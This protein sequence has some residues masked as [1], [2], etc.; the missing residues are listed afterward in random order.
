MA[1]LSTSPISPST[2]LLKV[3]NRLH[4]RDL[5]WGQL[6]T[7]VALLH[8]CQKNEFCPVAIGPPECYA[9][10]NSPT[11][12]CQAVAE[13]RGENHLVNH[14][15]CISITERKSR[16]RL[17]NTGIPLPSQGQLGRGGYLQKLIP[18]IF[19]GHTGISH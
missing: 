12:T 19:E 8:L 5:C 10:T 13:I 2:P 3:S 9:F 18:S 4:Y 16:A 6:E 15:G 7:H 11:F 14:S 17:K 1:F